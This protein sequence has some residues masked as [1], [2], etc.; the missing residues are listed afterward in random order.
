[1]CCQNNENNET[2]ELPSRQLIDV[3]P[4]LCKPLLRRVFSQILS[5]DQLSSVTQ[6]FYMLSFESPLRAFLPR[7]LL[8]AMTFF[9]ESSLT[10]QILNEFLF[11]AKKYNIYISQ[12][13]CTFVQTNPYKVDDDAKN[14]LRYLC[15]ATTDIHQDDIKPETASSIADTYNPPKFG[16]A[17]YFNKE[18]TQ[19]RET[20]KFECDN[21]KIGDSSNEACTKKYPQ[22]A[23]SGSTFLFL[24][25]CPLHGHCYEGH[26]VNGS[27]GRKDPASSL[28]NH[29][30]VAPEMIYYDFACSLEE[31]CMNREAGY[32]KNT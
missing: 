20:R 23:K 14:L 29:L 1:M 30:K 31:Y 24:W 13:V 12:F 2:F 25:F 22:V 5:L 6:L 19:I 27:E 28:Y 4:S 32:F 10:S 17:Y 26:I 3:F 8:E 16:R 21:S 7:P 15:Q 11:V 18:G 9:T